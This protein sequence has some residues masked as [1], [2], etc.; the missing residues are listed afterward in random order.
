S[1][2]ATARRRAD[3]TTSTES[4]RPHAPRAG[5]VASR[6]V[7]PD[8]AVRRPAVCALA[9]VLGAALALAA[10]GAATADPSPVAPLSPGPVPFGDDLHVIDLAGS[11]AA[12]APAD[13]PAPPAGAAEGFELLNPHIGINDRYTVRLVTNHGA[14]PTLDGPARDAVSQLAALTTA[15]ITLG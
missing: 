1:P 11:A 8:R 14:W 13:G 6:C 7:I 3:R 15:N 12:A 10:P 5:R 2:D 4:G 9:V